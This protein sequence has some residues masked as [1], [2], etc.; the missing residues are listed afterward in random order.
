MSFSKLI[1]HGYAVLVKCGAFFMFQ[2]RG[3]KL[4]YYNQRNYGNIPYPAPGL[5]PQAQKARKLAAINR[6]IHSDDFDFIMQGSRRGAPKETR[7][8]AA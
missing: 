8:V 6:R 3:K 1:I 4:I 7:R 5:R 2:K